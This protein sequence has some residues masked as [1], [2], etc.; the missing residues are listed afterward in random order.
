MINRIGFSYFKFETPA[1]LVIHYSIIFVPQPITYFLRGLLC[2]TDHRIIM[3]NNKNPMVN[4]M[5]FVQLHKDT[6]CSCIGPDCF[7]DTSSIYL[8]RIKESTPQETD[9]LSYWEEGKP[10]NSKKCD[11]ICKF[12]S[13]SLSKL[14]EESN[15]LDTWKTSYRFSPHYR[16]FYC[17]IRFN[18][19]AGFLWHTGSR[20]NVHHHSF[21]KADGFNLK[22]MQIIQVKNLSGA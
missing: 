4:E 6:D 5:T 17:E 16:P 12:R 2:V 20:N 19:K 7:E 3:E 1:L 21:F 11:K 14:V 8:R 18:P 10:L 9:F 22:S 15:I 13:V